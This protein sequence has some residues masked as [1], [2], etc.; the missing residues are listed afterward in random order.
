MPYMG[1]YTGGRCCWP[2]RAVIG[3]RARATLRAWGLADEDAARDEVAGR[4]DKGRSQELGEAPARSS[5][6][7]RDRRAQRHVVRQTHRQTPRRCDALGRVRSLG[8]AK[9]DRPAAHHRCDAA[10]CRRHHG[11]RRPS[12]RTH[13]PAPPQ[14]SYAWPQPCRAERRSRQPSPPRWPAAR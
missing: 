3:Q 6:S 13:G 8:A 10:A 5:C 7:A 2:G 9:R 14:P 1:W 4:G 12:A 11:H